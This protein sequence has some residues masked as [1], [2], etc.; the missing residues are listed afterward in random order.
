V[1]PHDNKQ[2]TLQKA[3]SAHEQAEAAL[4]DLTTDLSATSYAEMMSRIQQNIKELKTIVGTTLPGD[5]V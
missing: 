2:L 4:T 5:K 1:E 3:I